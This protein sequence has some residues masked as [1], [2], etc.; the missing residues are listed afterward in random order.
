MPKS[1]LPGI[2]AG[3][4]SRQKYKCKVC[5][6]TPRGCDLSKHYENKTDWKLLSEMKNSVGDAALKALKDKADPHTLFMF[7]HKYTKNSMPTWKTHVLCKET[8]N[9][10]MEKDPEEGTSS[11]ADIPPL[12]RS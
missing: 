4:I 10:Q 8:E 7:E 6:V 1:L 5:S 9:T 12:K 3:G 2:P 11:G